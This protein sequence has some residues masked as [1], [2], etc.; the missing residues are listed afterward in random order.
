MR[1]NNLKAL[2]GTFASDP[3][4]DPFEIKFT[5]RLPAVLN[6]FAMSADCRRQ[7]VTTLDGDESPIAGFRAG[8]SLVLTTQKTGAFV[9]ALRP[10]AEWND[11]TIS[12]E[13]L[14]APNDVGPPPAPY[15]N[16]PVPPASEAVLVGISAGDLGYTGT[17]VM[18]EQFWRLRS[19]SC[20][21]AP[22]E[23]RQINY[24]ETSGSQST[25][26]DQATLAGALGGS[27]SAGWGPL[28]A[29]L[30][31]SLNASVSFSQQTTIT[32]NETTYVSS[33]MTNDTDTTQMFLRW[34]L[35]DVISV[36]QPDGTLAANVT[37]ALAPAVVR[38]YDVAT[39][40]AA[41]PDDATDW[42]SDTIVK[43]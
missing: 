18:R 23:T 24:T 3:T 37:Q 12:H 42:S 5:V 19:E 26:S 15:A 33:T 40:P 14:N 22:G 27:V 38:T 2:T 34:Q 17:V 20:T 21:L 28:S 8:D 31:A 35:T 1:S 4:G 16:R 41:A 9:A 7:F 32:E 30:N 6:L 36:F 10:N 43:N 39:L 29:S 25:S 11:I 13:Q